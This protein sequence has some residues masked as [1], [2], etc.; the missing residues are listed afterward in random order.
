MYPFLSPDE[1]QALVLRYQQLPDDQAVEILDSP[2]TL[3]L[4]GGPPQAF[5]SDEI[6]HFTRSKA[7]QPGDTILSEGVIGIFV[8]RQ[9]G[10]DQ[11]VWAVILT[12]DGRWFRVPMTALIK[13]TT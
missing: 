4:N 12:V 3:Q 10:A 9:S 8:R 1:R 6:V 2:Q 7:S 13:V 5:T 11:H